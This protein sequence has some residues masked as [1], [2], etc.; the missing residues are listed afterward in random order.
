MRY[1]DVSIR[2][3]E[4]LRQLV[5]NR[6]RDP[7]NLAGRPINIGLVFHWRRKAHEIEGFYETVIEN[8]TSAVTNA[9]LGH[10]F[11]K[12]LRRRQHE[13]KRV[14]PVRQILVEVDEGRARD[15]LFLPSVRSGDETKA[16]SLRRH[17]VDPAINDA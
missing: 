17:Y 2:F 12:L 3:V 7:V 6:F 13:G 16:S 10:D 1:R 9:V 8:H 11:S 14:V 4:I 15:V 5:V